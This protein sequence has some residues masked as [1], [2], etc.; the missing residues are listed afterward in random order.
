MISHL[1]DNFLFP[2]G[3][4]QVVTANGAQTCAAC[5]EN[6][7][8]KNKG[9]SAEHDDLINSVHTDC[10]LLAFRLNKGAQKMVCQHSVFLQRDHAPFTVRGDVS[11]GYAPVLNTSSCHH[12][13]GRSEGHPGYQPRGSPALFLEWTDVDL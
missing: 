2:V 11:A 5:C 12:F 6:Q 10:D 9:P 7:T 4:V 3:Q 8:W 13:T 1:L